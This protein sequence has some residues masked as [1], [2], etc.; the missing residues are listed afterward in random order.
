MDWYQ[1]SVPRTV[2]DLSTDPSKGLSGED[3]QERIGKWGR[4][5]LAEPE[6]DGF[7]TRF[8]RHFTEFIIIV[9]IGAAV[10]AGALG[11]W[12]DS[13]AILAIVLLNGV[14]GF[15][16][17]RKAERVMEALKKLATPTARALRDGGL[18]SI[19]SADLVPGDI[20]VL[21]AGD[22]VPADCRVIETSF[23]KVDEAAL[24]GESQAVEKE[25]GAIEKTVPLADRTNMI[26]LGT[27]VVY[28]RGKAAV[29]STGMATEMGKIARLL[30][31]VKPEP[32]PL[33]KKLSEFGRRLVYAAGAI[34]A[35]IFVL[36]ILRGEGVVEMFLTSVSLAVAAI[37]EGLP[38]VVTITLALGVQRM[39]GRHVIIKKLP[40]VETLGSASVIASDKTGTITQNQMTVKKIY[41]S[42]GDIVAVTGSG[43]APDG[44]F[45][46]DSQEIDPAGS[47]ALTLAL[48]SGVLCNGAELKRTDGGW[49]V[50][51][52]P[53][54]GALLA[55]GLKAG[56]EKKSL[57]A[58]F[59]F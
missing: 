22:H 25:A 58:A 46:M 19:P 12:V 39:V 48:R 28:G 49:T 33:Q 13:I 53:T 29:V 2:E 56:I 32:T 42:T 35:L 6:K 17:E 38:A 3:A 7:L 30:Q 4:N 47:P 14:I 1:K 34:C 41:L 57:Y 15:V 26:Y 16:Q 27:T 20:I 50:I 59:G 9:L 40:S 11:E 43:Y 5:T 18:N 10:I 8:L 44:R 45:Y 37:P 51:G 52:D 21:D 23:L 31:G 36:G 24:T 55:L 54:E